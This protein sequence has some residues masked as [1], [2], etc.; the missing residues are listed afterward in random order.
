MFSFITIGDLQL[1]G[2]IK[3]E[4]NDWG[5]LEV[6]PLNITSNFFGVG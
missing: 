2:C 3:N 4:L 5:E 6:Q 1:V